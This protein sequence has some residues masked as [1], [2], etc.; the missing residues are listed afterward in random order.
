MYPKPQNPGLIVQVP[1]LQPA[2]KANRTGAL[3][4]GPARA[5]ASRRPT[6]LML[7]EVGLGGF[8]LGFRV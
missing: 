6:L 2:R 7:L 3:F 4:K 8:G 1:I 5:K